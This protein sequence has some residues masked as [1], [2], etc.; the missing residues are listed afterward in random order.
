ML[1]ILIEKLFKRE[2]KR[3]TKDEIERAILIKQA[4]DQFLKLREKGLSISVM[5]L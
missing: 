5:T 3:L 1:T 4:R 2:K